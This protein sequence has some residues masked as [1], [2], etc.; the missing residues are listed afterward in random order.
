MTAK[1]KDI[2]YFSKG[3]MPN[4]KTIGV[5]SLKFVIFFLILFY[6]N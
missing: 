1:M 5:L 3:V 4:F 6:N 2:P